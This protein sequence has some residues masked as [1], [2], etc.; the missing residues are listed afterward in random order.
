[1]RDFDEKSIKKTPE[2]F[3]GLVASFRNSAFAELRSAASGFETV[4]L[5]LFAAGVA[6]EHA[7]D[8]ESLALF[9]GFKE[10][11]SKAQA[12]GFGLSGESATGDHADDVIFVFD[13]KQS[14]GLFEVEDQGREGEIV[15]DVFPIDDDV[16]FAS[17]NINAG[18]GGFTAASAVVFGFFSHVYSPYL[19]RSRTLGC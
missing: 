4:F 15:L 11:A 5:T 17:G 13:A 16:A 12:N 14:Q 2:C 7:A 3:R 9:A 8:F 18:N 6:G 19:L 10:G 1:M